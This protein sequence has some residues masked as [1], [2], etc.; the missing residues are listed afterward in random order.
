MQSSTTGRSTLGPILALVG[1]ALLALGSF[2][3]WVRLTVQGFGSASAKGTDGSRGW[4]TFVAGAVLNA[5]ALAWMAGRRLKQAGIVAIVASLVGGGVGLYDALTAESRVINEVASR[6]AKAL[7]APEAAVRLALHAATR[8]GEVRIS[9]QLGLFAVIAGAVLG[10]IAGIL[11]LLGPQ[12]AS[13]GPV[14][15][16]V[17]ASGWLPMESPIGAPPEGGAGPA[18]AGLPEAEPPAR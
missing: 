8:T 5:C 18:E 13:A 3:P 9:V 16:T 2:F 6:F 17:V 4:I 15:E 10:L 1:G 7:G 11:A 12:P 14:A